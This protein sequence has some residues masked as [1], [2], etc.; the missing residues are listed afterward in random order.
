MVALAAPVPEPDPADHRPA[1]RPGDLAALEAAQDALA[2]AGRLLPRLAAPPAAR[3]RRL[4]RPD[5][6]ARARHGRSAHPQQP[7][8]T[9][10]AR[11]PG[12]ATRPRASRRTARPVRELSA[13]A[14]RTARSM[15]RL[16]SRVADR[17]AL[18]VEVLAA[19][20]RDLDLGVRAREVD[21]RRH[22]R[23]PALA[24]SAPRAA[25]A[26]AGAAAAC[27]GARDRGS[28]ARPG[29]YGGMCTECSHS[30]P[31]RIAA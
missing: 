6:R 25:R 27:A 9:A 3:R 23:Q 5:R 1:R 19:G 17:L 22:Q 18:V 7:A 28:R 26:R 2:R 13:C 21:P 14:S 24:D 20:E 4:H 30:S 29:P 10:S 15:S 16:V 11:H 31:S 8:A 12:V